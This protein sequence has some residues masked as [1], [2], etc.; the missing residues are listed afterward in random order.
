MAA[1]TADS[2]STWAVARRHWVR[3]D[4]YQATS[5]CREQLAD[6]SLQSMCCSEDPCRFRIEA[7]RSRVGEEAGENLV[8]AGSIKTAAVKLQSSDATNQSWRSAN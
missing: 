5:V 3:V 2:S 6:E 4:G 7:P 1:A 8:V